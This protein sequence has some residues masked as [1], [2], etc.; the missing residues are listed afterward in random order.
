MVERA[1]LVADFCMAARN[2]DLNT[3]EECCFIRFV[4]FEATDP[5]GFRAIHHAASMGH[6]HILE[7]L[8]QRL[9]VNANSYSRDGLTAL[10]CACIANRLDLVKYLVQ[11]CHCDLSV[12]TRDQDGLT[13]LDSAQ[14]LGH[15]DVV[16]FLEQYLR[17]T[18]SSNT[19][20]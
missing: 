8:I 12:T 20:I 11:D 4:D 15:T 10:H 3:M 1:N 7:F 5:N 2:G 14:V 19:G 13:P 9:H 6:R 16:R 17:E 18:V